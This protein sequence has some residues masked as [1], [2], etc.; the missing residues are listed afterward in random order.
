MSTDARSYL[1]SRQAVLSEREAEELAK[2]DTSTPE[3]WRRQDLEAWRAYDPAAQT[4]ETCW[5][6]LIGDTQHGAVGE[7]EQALLRPL[8]EALTALSGT[9]DVAVELVGVGQGST[10]MELRPAH[11]ESYSMGDTPIDASKAD[12][13][14]RDLLE[15][16]ASFEAEEDNPRLN[17]AA[18]EVADF[19]KA[20][21]RIE[22]DAE[23]AWEGPGGR[24]RAGRVTER[25]RG[26]VRSKSEPAASEQMLHVSGRV[27]M[28]NDNGTVRLKTGPHRNDRTYDVHF[29]D[30][31]R[32]LMPISLGSQN[33]HFTVRE[34]TMKDGFGTVTGTPRLVFES[35]TRHT[36]QLNL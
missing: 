26:Y 17:R 23:V 29:E 24:L 30:D 25:G 16:L 13:A 2:A 11:A 35:L 7:G 10:V 4:R 18:Q 15:V 34:V 28:L 20:L 19:V 12:D 9:P 31:K 6:R 5:L 1:R 33:L 8:N 27:V 36:D 32:H 22:V 3:E 21:D 14:F